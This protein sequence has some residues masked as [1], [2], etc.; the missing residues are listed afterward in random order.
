MANPPPYVI[1][2]TTYMPIKLG[3]GVGAGWD[4]R[5]NGEIPSSLLIHATQGT[6]GSSFDGEAR[7]LATSRTVG[8]HL[9]TGR[10]GQ[11]A[12]IV[13]TALRAHHAGQTLYTWRN[14]TSIGIETHW[15]FGEPWP[16]AGTDALT[17]LVRRLMRQYTIPVARIQSHRFAA[18]PKGRKSDPGYWTD[19]QFNQWLLTLSEPVTPANP[20]YAVT[21][22]RANVRSGPAIVFPVTMVLNR[23]DSFGADSVKDGWHHREDGR[24]FVSSAVVRRVK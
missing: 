22:A 15:T 6:R 21:T 19:Q 13:P 18:L 5:V 2:T 16:Q 20:R 9:L 8:A 17:W 11:I 24:G 10:N 4:E 7:Y 23:G 1:D 12:Q 3:L 14:N